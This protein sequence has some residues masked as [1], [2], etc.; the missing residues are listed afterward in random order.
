MEEAKEG[1]MKSEFIQFRIIMPVN[2]DQLYFTT[3][4]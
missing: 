1:H 2:I 4:C 3:K